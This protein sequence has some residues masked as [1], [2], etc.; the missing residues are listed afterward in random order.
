MKTVKIDKE[1]KTVVYSDL[2]YHKT[3]AT[4]KKLNSKGLFLLR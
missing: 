2:L 1:Y 3:K 4:I